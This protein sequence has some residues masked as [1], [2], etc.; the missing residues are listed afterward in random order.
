MF[1]YRHAFHAG[2]HADVLKHL[3]LVHLLQHLNQKEKGYRV[4]DTHAGTGGYSLRSVEANKKLEW[5]DGI[6]RLWERQ[7]LPKGVAAYLDQVEVFNGPGVLK[8][9]PGSPSLIRQLLRPQDEL[10]AF[11]MQPQD[12]RSLEKLMADDKR[13]KVHLSDGFNGLKPLLPPPTRRGLVLMDPPYEIKTDYTR[14]LGSVREILTRFPDA[15]VAV[16]IPQVQLVEAQQLPQRLRNAVQG[17]VKKGWLDAQ[18]TVAPAQGGGFG[19]MGSHMFV[20]NPPHTLG[21]LLAE[22]LPWL[23]SAMAQFPG[24]KGQLLAG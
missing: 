1:A 5:V 11:E 19:L 2:N 20:A 4:I 18:L 9:V 22:E 8:Q 24:A 3:V 15:V 6:G 17:V 23:A 14:V 21:T 10:H 12:M 16:W 7:D 13:V